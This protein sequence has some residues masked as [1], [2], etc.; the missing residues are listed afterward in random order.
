MIWIMKL[1][2]SKSRPSLMFIACLSIIRDKK[3]QIRRIGVKLLPRPEG[4]IKIFGDVYPNGVWSEL[5]HGVV[6]HILRNLVALASFKG[7]SKLRTCTGF[8]IDYADKCPTILTS[9]SLVRKNDAKIIEGLRIVVLLP[10]RERCEGKLEHYSLH[11]NVALVSVKNYTVDCPVDLNS[12]HLDWSTKLLAVGRCF[13]SGLAMAASG[14]CTRWSGNLDCKDLQY[15]ACTITKAG[16]GGP[17]VAVNGKFVG[18]NYYNRN[19][20]TPFLWFD[21][22]RGI[23]NYFKT[24]QTNYMKIIHG[25]SGLL[26]K[27]GCIVKDGEQQPPNR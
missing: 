19:M 17:L 3:R 10:N 4:S 5:E 1:L 21:L 23:L 25:S 6:S 15:T 8:F 11:Y 12:E 16:I 2:L 13:E 24:G 7:E 26:C 14:K 27:L 18:M 22:L 20:G 9:A